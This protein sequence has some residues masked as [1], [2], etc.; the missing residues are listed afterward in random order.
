MED[1]TFKRSFL[2]SMVIHVLL[3]AVAGSMTLFR[4][5]GITYSPSYT[6]D[7]VTL[8][9]SPEPASPAPRPAAPAQV[10]KPEKQPEKQPE[11][12]KPPAKEP[13][14][15]VTKPT[16]RA[17]VKPVEKVEP[18]KPSGGDEAA[19]TERRRRIEELEKEAR[20]L[21]ESFTA[22]S[23]G[24]AEP[25]A[26]SSEPTEPAV[27][28]T[29]AGAGAGQP[30]G[31][32]AGRAADIRNRVYY[33][34]IW[35]LIRSSWYLPEGVAKEDRLLTVVGIR[36]AP[37]GVIERSWI[38]RGSGNDYYDQSALRAIRRSSPLP[39]LPKDLGNEPLEVGINFRYPE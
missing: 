37:D 16:V 33:D 29:A 31:G 9:A 21:Y 3:L 38:E 12:P 10:V 4:M 26:E 11:K 27:S 25:V 28:Q 19:Q 15:Q 13:E 1:R 14:P 6:V 2:V 22:D 5:N 23:S 35:G 24:S 8:P 36:I 34:R 18:V 32:R 17:P 7:L 20:R 30:A 39:S